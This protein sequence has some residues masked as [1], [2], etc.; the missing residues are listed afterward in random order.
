MPKTRFLYA[1]RYTNDATTDASVGIRSL[2]GRT[3]YGGAGAERTSQDVFISRNMQILSRMVDEKNI[4]KTYQLKYNESASSKNSMREAAMQLLKRAIMP[5]KRTTCKVFGYP[6]IKLTGSAQTG[7]GFA[8]GNT[9]ASADT[10]LLVPADNP[11][12]YGGRAGMLVEKT[13][14]LDGPPIDM[15]LPDTVT[16]AGIK[17]PFLRSSTEWDTNSYYRIFIHLRAGM[18]VRVQHPAAGVIGNHIC[19]RLTYY[20]RMGTTETTIET[21]G[22]DE[23]AIKRQGQ[24]AQLLETIKTAGSNLKPEYITVK[25]LSKNPFSPGS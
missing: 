25:K 21:T 8:G 12:A 4:S 2:V 16:S 22:Y 17:G 19:T 7:T 23:A 13:T 24:L 1:D 18:S 14:G 9:S 10:E 5:S 3:L 15:V 11:I 20:E 6:V